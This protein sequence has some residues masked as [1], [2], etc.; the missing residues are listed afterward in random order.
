MTFTFHQALRCALLLTLCCTSATVHAEEAL[1]KQDAEEYLK[2]AWAK[3]MDDGSEEAEK[4][5]EQKSVTAGT[6]TM[7]YH[8]K[9]FGEAPYGKRSLWISM[10]GG[11]GAPKK[12]NDQ[13]WMNQGRLYQL[14]EGF[15]ITPRAPTDTWNLWHQSHIDSLFG[16]LI[17]AYVVAEGVDPNRIYIM[18]YSAGGDGVYQLAPRMADRLAAAA[19]MAG[20]PNETK[21]DGLRNLAFAL[22]VGGKDSAYNRNV[23]GEKWKTM[24]AELHENDPGGYIHKAVIFPQHAHW[25]NGDDREAIPWMAHYSRKPWPDK[26]IWLQDDVTHT[27]FYWLSVPEKEAVKGYKVTAW[28]TGQEIHVESDD[29][30]ELTLRLHDD[31]INLDKPITVIAHSTQVFQGKVSRQ[32]AAIDQ[33]LEQRPDPKSACFAILTIMIKKPITKP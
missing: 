16:K 7:P 24:L 4:L 31:L 30:C 6:F 23:I 20:H 3:I 33:S 5:I 22:Y 8:V 12:V 28:V 15:Y 26:V 27:R 1:S 13:Q 32:K 17:D 11:G 25:M 2:Q 29:I 10:H 19:M 18:G 14:E 9:Y 21:P